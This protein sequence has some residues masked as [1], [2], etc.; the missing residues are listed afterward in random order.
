MSWPCLRRETG[1]NSQFA[2]IDAIK[3]NKTVKAVKPIR[4]G[5]YLWPRLSSIYEAQI[6]TRTPN[7]TRRHRL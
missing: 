5:P 4:D 3:S 2:E 6:R 1:L 7:M